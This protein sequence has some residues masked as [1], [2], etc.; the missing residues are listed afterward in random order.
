MENALVHAGAT[1]VEVIVERTGAEDRIVVR[2]DGR[3][4]REDECRGASEPFYQGSEGGQGGGLGLAIARELA[5]AHGGSVTAANDPRGGACFT[6]RCRSRR[7]TNRSRPA[8]AEAPGRER[9]LP[10][11]ALALALLGLLVEQGRGGPR[12]VEVAVA[13][14]PIA[15][16]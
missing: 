5:E 4:L 3:G 13:A 15:A 7:I 12:T 2:D 6:S 11:A 10:L 9:A 14:S 16:G 1:A 8:R